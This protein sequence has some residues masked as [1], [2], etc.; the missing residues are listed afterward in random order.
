MRLIFTDLD[1]SLLDHY[2]YSFA[3]AAHYLERLEAQQIPVIPIT[4][5]TRAEVLALRQQLKNQHPFIIENGA[6][7]CIPRDYFSQRP[8]SAIDCEDYWIISNA[9]PSSHWQALL[10]Q[11]RP[12]FEDEFQTFSSVCGKKGTDGLV[13]LTGL[14]PDQARLARQREYSETIHWL[15]GDSRKAEFITQLKAAG[16][17]LLQ[18]GRFLSMGDDTD[19]GRALA[20]LL[21]L[22]Q[23]Q[24]GDCQTL[25]IGDSANDISMLE[26]ADSA[27]IIRS[28]NHRAP[29]VQRTNNLYASKATGPNGWVEGVYAWLENHY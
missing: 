15:G 23:Q 11:I 7:I 21:H 4:S 14:S 13:Q 2:S 5:K 6:A 26:A 3:P 10:D 22:Y 9:R 28:P 18:G 16:A 24:H 25:A 1:G 17:H 8:G 12:A 20:Q 27:L 29:N 19:K